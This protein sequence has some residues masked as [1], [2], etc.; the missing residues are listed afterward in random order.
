MAHG[1]YAQE[2]A[3]LFC[4]HPPFAWLQALQHKACSQVR[5][6]LRST[7]QLLAHFSRFGGRSEQD[8]TL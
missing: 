2:V 7:A 3:H 4:R 5:K 6:K 8:E 1:Q